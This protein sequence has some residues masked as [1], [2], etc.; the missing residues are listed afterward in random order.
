[1]EAAAQIIVK[2]PRKRG[3]LSTFVRQ[4]LRLAVYI[5]DNF[6]CQW[7]MALGRDVTLSLDHIKPRSKDGQHH[8]GNLVTAC[9]RCNTVRG[10]R[11]VAKFARVVA[12]YVNGGTTVKE[13]LARIRHAC[14]KQLPRDEAKVLVQKYG[15]AFKATRAICEVSRT[16]E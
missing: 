5:R 15:S 12:A 4:D 2:I 8:A 10:N 14:Y 6:Q 9:I 13:I 7:C 1:M 16:E 11:S 3:H